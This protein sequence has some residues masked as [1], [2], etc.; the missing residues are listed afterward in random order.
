MCYASYVSYDVKYRLV[1]RNVCVLILMADSVNG[2]KI[3]QFFNFERYER[4][5]LVLKKNNSFKVY[6]LSSSIIVEK[7][8]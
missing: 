1:N 7:C 4:R 8:F 6:R 5:T 2:Y 3:R